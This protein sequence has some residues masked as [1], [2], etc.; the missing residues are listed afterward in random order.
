M[1]LMLHW[2]LVVISGVLALIESRLRQTADSSWEFL[3]TNRQW[4]DEN[5]RKNSHGWK[6]RV[7]LRR[8][9]KL[10]H[11][12]Q[13]HVCRVFRKRDS[14]GWF[15]VLRNFYARTCVKFPFA[16]KIREAMHERSLV[17]VTELNLAQLLVQAQPFLSCLYFIYVIKIHVR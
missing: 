10:S 1:A 8:S 4:A 14:K 16:N 2:R 9:K 17:S 13:I 12:A 11:V 7:F 5:S 6:Q 15:P 3:K